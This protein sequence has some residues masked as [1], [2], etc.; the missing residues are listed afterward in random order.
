MGTTG[1]RYVKN[2]NI[3][4]NLPAGQQYYVD[5]KPYYFR[6]NNK[7]Y[8][9]SLTGIRFKFNI[10]DPVITI[11][12]ASDISDNQFDLRTLLKDPS[13][14]LA[15]NRIYGVYVQ[16][17]GQEPVLVGEATSGQTKTF[18]NVT[19]TGDE[20]VIIVKYNADKTNTGVFNEYT[21]TYS[22]PMLSDIYI[23]NANIISY[24]DSPK[25]RFTFTNSYKI[26][27]VDKISY[28]IYDDSL[29]IMD[30][31]DSFEPIWGG[32]SDTY[33]YFDMNSNV[34]TGSYLIQLQLYSEGELV[35]NVSL[36]YIKG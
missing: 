7:I 34:E 28:T 9:N 21:Y 23:G 5:I 18:S 31:N 11:S 20:C 8:L 35:G 26:N 6:N 17:E 2:V 1:G 22:M 10:N 36:D 19:C 16:S 33:M 32:S 24:S 29:N 27:E 15:G 12:R 25:I 13:N 30:T 4:G 3:N 14:A